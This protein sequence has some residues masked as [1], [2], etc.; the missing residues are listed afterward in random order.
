MLIDIFLGLFI[1]IIFGIIAGLLPG[2]HT[3]LIVVLL[4]SVASF[5]SSA[6][7]LLLVIIIITTAIT[8]S[9]VDAVPS[10]FL[11]ASEDVL[12]LLPGHKLLKKGAGIE[13]VKFSVVGSLLGVV[14]GLFFI[15]VFILLFPI[16]FTLL[17]PVL[18]WILL[19][20]VM[21][22][23]IREKSV[24]P[25]IIFVLAGLLGM[26]TLDVIK[27]PLFP[28]LSGLFGASTLLFSLLKQ[29]EI[30][31]QRKT[32]ILRLPKKKLSI[33]VLTGVLAGSIVTLFPGLSPAQAAALM[34]K[35]KPLQ[36]LVLLGSIGT[37]DVLISL[38]TFFTINKTRNGAVVG[39]NQLVGTISSELL[40]T[41]LSVCCVA[42]GVAVIFSLFAAKWYA[43][44][45]DY[46]EYD[47]ISVVVLVFLFVM[48]FF[49]SGL[50][51]LLVFITATAVGLL[52]PLTGCSRSHAMGCLLIPTLVVLW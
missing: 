48:T 2:I 30:P 24:W 19:A 20:L 38:V 41:L 9:I 15:P 25:I 8:S 11:G 51:G 32:D 52:A 5:L 17:K 46:I 14:S 39:I 31:I 21:F 12:S 42:T 47:W 27:Q 16:L 22:L 44:L 18:F 10:V 35:Q 43:S 33:S 26:L 50:L 3:N 6:D 37:I 45:L 49:L 7:L 36:F 4:V 40:V 13:A 34:P 28:L 23:V 1:G 29:V